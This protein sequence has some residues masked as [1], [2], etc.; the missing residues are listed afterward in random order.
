M[1][2]THEETGETGAKRDQNWI[3][4]YTIAKAH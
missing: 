1:V 2:E 3:V 4:N